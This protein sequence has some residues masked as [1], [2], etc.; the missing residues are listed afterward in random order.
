MK[1]VFTCSKHAPFKYGT[2]G[3]LGT[4]KGM[5][6]YMILMRDRN[7]SS[8]P[9]DL[10]PLLGI[11]SIVMVLVWPFPGRGP[12]IKCIQLKASLLHT[13][14]SAEM[15]RNEILTVSH[16]I[17]GLVHITWIEWE[18]QS[19]SL[20]PTT[21]QHARRTHMVVPSLIVWVS[22]MGMCSSMGDSTHVAQ[23]F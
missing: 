6:D 18:L 4:I 15:G 1:T 11:P 13:S 14:H 9:E 7:W 3:V 5:V 16:Q 17:Q 20:L 19:G 12:C 10:C 21:K 2:I 22:G 23:G 8:W